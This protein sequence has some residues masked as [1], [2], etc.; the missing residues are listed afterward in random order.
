MFLVIAH[1]TYINRISLPI[2]VVAIIQLQRCIQQK[3]LVLVIVEE[4]KFVLKT[5]FSTT[6][7]QY[8][9]TH[10]LTLKGYQRGGFSGCTPGK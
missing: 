3:C 7:Q 4:L 1:R 6:A 10:T 5:K 9:H 2:C 8:T